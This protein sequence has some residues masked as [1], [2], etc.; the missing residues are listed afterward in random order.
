[1][2]YIDLLLQYYD[3]LLNHFKPFET[4]LTNHQKEK[5]AELEAQLNKLYDSD[6]ISQI[7]KGCD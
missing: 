1:M 6:M 5:W 7:K 4:S 3:E 2:Q